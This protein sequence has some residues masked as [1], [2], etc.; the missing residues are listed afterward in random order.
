MANAPQTERRRRD[1]FLQRNTLV[2]R[3]SIGRGPSVTLHSMPMPR[4]T[5]PAALQLAAVLLVAIGIGACSSGPGL[6]PNA[7]FSSSQPQADGQAGVSVPDIKRFPDIPVATKTRMENKRTLI[8]GSGEGWYGQLGM[9]TE[10]DA[11]FMFDFYQ[12]ELN[13]FGWQE[14]TSV[15]AP[16][17]VLTYERS[18]RILSI[19]IENK[20]L[21]GTQVT[22]TVSPRGGMPAL[23]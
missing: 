4:R 8:F 14:V 12:R 18:G 19:Q 15:R 9:A 23:N 20:Q 16:V 6:S 17:S 2:S 10:H 7:S 13:R 22:L 1:G 5:K 3:L 21:L 11:D